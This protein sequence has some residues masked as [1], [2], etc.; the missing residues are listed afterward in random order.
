MEQGR[1]LEESVLFP[2]AALT[3]QETKAETSALQERVPEWKIA[4]EKQ[5]LG[6]KTHPAYGMRDGLLYVSKLQ[7]EGNKWKLCVPKERKLEILQACHHDTIS[8]HF[9]IARTLA[10]VTQRFYWKSLTN[11]VIKYVNAFPSCQSRKR[12]PGKI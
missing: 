9:G 1:E 2:I 12:P 3:M 6:L 8:G 4:I 5:Q 7:L 10:R 11:D